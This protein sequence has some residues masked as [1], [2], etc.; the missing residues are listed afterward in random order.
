MQSKA[1]RELPGH[2]KTQFS[3]R[4]DVA[5]GDKVWRQNG[6]S[7]AQPDT[8]HQ[9]KIEDG[10]IIDA[11]LASDVPANEPVVLVVRHDARDFEAELKPSIETQH[12]AQ[13]RNRFVEMLEGRRLRI[14]EDGDPACSGQRP[15]AR[16]RI[17]HDA[18]G[19]VSLW[20]G[21][22]C[23][24]S[25]QTQK[26]RDKPGLHGGLV[27]GINIPMVPFPARLRHAYI[28]CLL[29][30]GLG[31]TT[32]TGCSDEFP[33]ELED[34]AER[35]VKMNEAVI[36]PTPSDPHDGN[37]NVYACNVSVDQLVDSEGNQLRP[38]PPGTIVIKESTRT[39]HDF[40]WLRAVA[41]RDANGWSWAEYTRNFDNEEFKQILAP[42]SLCTDCHK[43][44]IAKDWIFTN[45][46]LR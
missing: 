12:P 45:Y 27:V 37:K 40:V 38:L 9:V 33:G 30:A 21:R 42:E 10:T 4:H 31:M 18:G 24:R 43:D 5:F 15:L 8:K 19:R 22:D 2:V 29:L 6:G 39:Y 1:G 3:P 32:F 17:G 28:L 34:Y 14:Q 41:R 20:G 11:P 46:E 36:P 13:T 44:A 26:K 23:G 35:C 7:G 25:S 16:R